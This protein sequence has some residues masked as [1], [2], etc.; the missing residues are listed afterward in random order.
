MTPPPPPPPAAIAGYHAHIY[1]EPATR[2]TA[3]AVRIG[4]IAHFVLRLGRWRDRPVGPHP[5]PMFQAAFAPERFAEIVPW[6]MLNRRG[7]TV[8]VHPDTG[9][10]LADHRD[11][12]LWLG[13]PLPLD[14]SVLD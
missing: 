12:P 11:Y 1:Y 13:T 2:P 7:H 3:A 5:L 10:D 14:L 4:L 8:L 9:D 6:L